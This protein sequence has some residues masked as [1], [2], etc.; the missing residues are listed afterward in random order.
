ME[1][2]N[3]KYKYQIKFKMGL[4]IEDIDKKLKLYGL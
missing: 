1:R 3:N 2:Q 4:V